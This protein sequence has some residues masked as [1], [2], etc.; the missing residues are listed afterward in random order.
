VG[1]R[2]RPKIVGDLPGI[3]H[4]FVDRPDEFLERPGDAG[5]TF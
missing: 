5:S 3:V 2:R 4:A 1:E